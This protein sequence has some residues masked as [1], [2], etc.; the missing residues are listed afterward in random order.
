MESRDHTVILIA[1][2]L[3][4][5]RNADK[6]AVVAHGH[7]VEFGSHEELIE[8]EDGR[9]QRLFES[10]KRKSSINAAGLRKSHAAKLKEGAADEEEEEEINWEE[11]INE[12]E[13]IKLDTARAR[14]MASPDSFYFF[15]GLVGAILSGGGKHRLFFAGIVHAFILNRHLTCDGVILSVPNVGCPVLGDDRS[16]VPSCRSLQ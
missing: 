8:K 16:S 14:S 5:V 4:T 10:S 1:H 15:V 13:D 7:V 3:S 11:K 2:R 9:Y 6:I 12:E